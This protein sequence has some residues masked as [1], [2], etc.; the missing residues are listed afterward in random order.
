MTSGSFSGSLPALVTPMLP[1][2]GV[3]FAAWARLV[4]FHVANGSLG[5]VIGGTTGESATLTD[6][7]LREL[8]VTARNLASGRLQIVAGAGTNNTAETLRRVQWLAELQPDALLLVTPAYNRPTQEGLYQHFA[9]AAA[10]SALPVILYN[11]PSRTGVDLLP[12]TTARLSQLPG[13]VALKEAVPA[14]ERIRELVTTCRPG[15]QILSGDDATAREAVT[16]G[17]CGMI[18]VTANVAPALCSQLIVAAAAGRRQEAAQIDERLTPLNKALFVESNPIP[19][20]WALEQM[21]LI[22][23][24]IR[25][26]LTPLSPAH[27]RTVHNALRYAGID[28]P[29][30]G[31]L[32]S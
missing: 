31:H 11:V 24:A 16:A 1:D 6:A 10:A 15:F 29:A 17:A 4:D 14:M 20:K 12:Q 3:D 30:A 7:E 13:I 22:G 9:A 26:P 8:V 21:G 32:E 5:V 19:V 25:L 27:H 18:S 2:G 23:G 28:V